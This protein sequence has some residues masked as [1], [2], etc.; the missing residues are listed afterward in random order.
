MS[1]VKIGRV[2]LNQYRV[3][4]FI[5]GGGVGLV[6]RV[7]DLKMNTDLAMKILNI[8][9][10]DDPSS[11]FLFKREAKAYEYLAHPNIVRYYGVKHSE[12]I[13]FLLLDFIDG[14][15]LQKILSRQ[16]DR[17]LPIPDVLS[18]FKALSAAL[19]YAH[20]NN[21]VHCDI[22]PGN[23]LVDQGGKVYL[24]DFG[25]ARH[26]ESTAT[27]IG[28]AG[29]IAYMAPEQFLKEPLHASTDIYSMGVLLYE[30]LI[31]QKPFRP[32]NQNTTD[33]SR[34]AR[35]LLEEA[36]LKEPPPDPCLIR[37][38]L[39]VDVGQVVIK[40]MQK[41]PTQRFQSTRE[42]FSALCAAFGSSED[43]VADRIATRF[44]E[45]TTKTDPIP[46]SPV[47]PPPTPRL[48]PPAWTYVLAGVAVI[49]VILFLAIQPKPGNVPT[50]VSSNSTPTEEIVSVAE[51]LPTMTTAPTR[52]SAPPTATPTVEEVAA[53]GNTISPKD[54]MPMIY[55]PEGTFI[56][57]SHLCPPKVDYACEPHEVYLDGYWIDQYEV[58]NEMYRQCVDDGDCE[59]PAI[60][61]SKKRAGYFY[62]SQYEDYPVI[63]VNRRNAV[64]YCEWAGRR[65][66]TEA[67][68]EKAAR[69]DDERKFPW[70]D[71]PS[72]SY[73]N[74]N[75]YIGDTTPVGAYSNGA[76]PYGVMDMAGNV[77]EWVADYYYY[78]SSSVYKNPTGP[79]QGDHYVL[80][81]GSWSNVTEL[82]TTYFRADNFAN[83]VNNDIGFRCADD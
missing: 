70:G 80:R 47:P 44:I 27:D 40:A 10:D 1:Q 9:T 69:G 54:N 71:N 76:S 64:D 72:S 30:M 48:K 82:I 14:D 77:W 35:E 79:A 24:T 8:D 32:S 38:D 60:V 78:Y 67:E 45:R 13:Y 3:D 68:W 11:A 55:I 23:I 73:A 6:Y 28:A 52:T 56:M 12:G 62:S 33:Q 5:G 43:A 81:G 53:P 57:G 18:L 36:H 34:T 21:V 50:P 39:P 41:D 75:Y 2:L 17:R 16:P 37:K 42:F 29:T 66:P 25:I 20:N 22:K 15:S 61:D 46:P 63:W 49:G 7:R 26:M 4:E 58:T 31:G 59:T 74:Y 51:V 65:L 19:G 83:F